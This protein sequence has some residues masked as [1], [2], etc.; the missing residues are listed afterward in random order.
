MDIYGPAEN[1]GP[2]KY[3][4]DQAV[5]LTDGRKPVA[6][7]ENGVIPDPDKPLATHSA[8]LWYMP[9]WGG[10]STFGKSNSETHVKS[11]YDHPYTITLDELPSWTS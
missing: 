6:L 11:V 9:W 4:F 5:G 7:T 1:Y 8:W 3:A 10:G 2:L